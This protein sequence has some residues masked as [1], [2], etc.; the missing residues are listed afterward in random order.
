MEDG[1]VIHRA[2]NERRTRESVS[3][4]FGVMRGLFDGVPGPV[5]FDA[6]KSPGTD[7]DGWQAAITNLEST[8]SKVAMLIDPEPSSEVGPYPDVIDRLLIPLKVFTDETEA[9]AFLRADTGPPAQGGELPEPPDDAVETTAST[10]W[11]EDGIILER[12]NGVRSTTET[13][14]EIFDVFRD[15]TGGTPAP[16]LFDARKWPGGDV[17]AWTTAVANLESTLT[18]FALLVE[19]ES[20]AGVGPFVLDRLTIPFEVFTDEAAAL[21][22]LRGTQSQ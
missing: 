11:F 13:A 10:V 19:P 21:A 17:E 14:S 7:A 5:L 22:F 20:R 3:E 16:L 18:A 15:L 6:R 1:I 8:A 9:L 2:N 4:L 12:F